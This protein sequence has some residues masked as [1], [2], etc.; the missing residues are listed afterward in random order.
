M[1][2]GTTRAHMGVWN[3]PPSMPP[4]IPDATMALTQAETFE[5]RGGGGGRIEL[6]KRESKGKTSRG[7]E[8]MGGDEMWLE[9]GRRARREE[10]RHRTMDDEGGGSKMGREKTEERKL[11]DQQATT[12]TADLDRVETRDHN[13]RDLQLGWLVRQ[14]AIA[15]LQVRHDVSQLRPPVKVLLPQ[16]SD[17]ELGPSLGV[18]SEGILDYLRQDLELL[19]PQTP[20]DEPRGTERSVDALQVG[21][22]HELPRFVALVAEEVSEQHVRGRRVGAPS[23]YPADEMEEAAGK[24]RRPGGHL[25]REMDRSLYNEKEFFRDLLSSR[26]GGNHMLSRTFWLFW[27]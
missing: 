6:K 19:F 16:H 10:S 1:A 12:K 26:G 24:E 21:L 20:H 8:T 23:P 5:G 3:V 11:S 22:A 15:L 13:H 9:P 18:D 14:D 17:R 25:T 4:L 27:R 7:E 2:F